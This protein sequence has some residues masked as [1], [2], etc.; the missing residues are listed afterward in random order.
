M[1]KLIAHCEAAGPVVIPF[2]H[3]GM[4]RVRR[5]GPPG[6]GGG[7]E[8]SEDKPLG[9]QA[10]SGMRAG[11]AG[12]VGGGQVLPQYPGT[13]RQSFPPKTGNCIRIRVG[14]P[15]Q[16][17]RAPRQ[18]HALRRRLV[19]PPAAGLT[20]G[21]RYG[22][23]ATRPRSRPGPA[24][25]GGCAACEAGPGARGRQVQDLIDAAAQRRSEARRAAGASESWAGRLCRLQRVWVGHG[26]TGATDPFESCVMKDTVLA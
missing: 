19:A 24:R 13:R 9:T 25:L 2:Y 7:S 20:L 1:G 14:E 10:G 4:H 15:V 16:V 18:S 8:G 23:L 26:G 11:A 22:V 12:R 6:D 3:T 21:S 17:P 5:P